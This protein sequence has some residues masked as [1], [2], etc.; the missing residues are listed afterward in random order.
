MEEILDNLFYRGEFLNKE[1]MENGEI[2]YR[3]K[4]LPNFILSKTISGNIPKWQNAHYHNLVNEV[5]FVRKGQIL[6]AIEEHENITYKLLNVGNSR[7]IRPG[8]KHN[9][10]LFSNTIIN[11]L[12]Y[13]PNVESDWYLAKNLNNISKKFNV[14]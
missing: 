3:T 10:Y 2:R 6:L 1:L 7:L 12:K 11:V 5:Y 13:G 14:K 9:V 4:I 8:V